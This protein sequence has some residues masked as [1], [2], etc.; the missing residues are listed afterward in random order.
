MMTNGQKK[1][2]EDTWTSVGETTQV[3][4]HDFSLSANIVTCNPSVTTMEF[5]DK[6]DFMHSNMWYWKSVKN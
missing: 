2:T 4:K 3:F 1:G 6:L 5:M